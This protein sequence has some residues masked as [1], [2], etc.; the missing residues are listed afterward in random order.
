MVEE[1]EERLEDYWFKKFS[2]QRHVDDLLR[3]FCIER[4]KGK[5]AYLFKVI[6]LIE[7]FISSHTCS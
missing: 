5:C 4:A 7:E 3:W 2:K 1:Y 6:I